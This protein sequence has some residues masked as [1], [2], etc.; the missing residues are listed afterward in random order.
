MSDTANP[1]A[2]MLDMLKEHGW[3][4]THSAKRHTMTGID[5]V[6]R[7]CVW[8]EGKLFG[9]DRQ[10]Y[11]AED[12]IVMLIGEQRDVDFAT[13]LSWQE[14]TEEPKMEKPVPKGVRSLFAEE[15]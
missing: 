14:L 9:I 5:H 8:I 4:C 10:A 15:D 6:A 11:L 2:A 3:T 13:F 7:R 12:G 1:V